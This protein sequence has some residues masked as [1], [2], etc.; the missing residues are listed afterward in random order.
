MEDKPEIEKEK[1][2]ET[3]NIQDFSN[4]AIPMIYDSIF[5]SPHHQ[6]KGP[7]TSVE[8]LF[9]E[10]NKLE[11]EKNITI[12][13]SILSFY[14]YL[15]CLAND[16][17][18]QS[19]IPEEYRGAIKDI[20]NF[21]YGGK[22]L[23]IGGPTGL[24]ATFGDIFS[25]KP[26]KT[27][28]IN[29]YQEKFGPKNDLTISDSIKDNIKKTD[30]KTTLETKS[31]GIEDIEN[32]LTEKFDV[33]TAYGCLGREN[34]AKFSGSKFGPD[35]STKEKRQEILR[36]VASVIKINGLFIITIIR[37][38]IPDVENFW[39]LSDEEVKKINENISEGWR[40]K[41]EYDYSP[42]H[43]MIRPGF[44]K[45]EIEEAG[46]KIITPFGLQDKIFVLQFKGSNP[47]N[48]HVYPPEKE[49][50]L[51]ADNN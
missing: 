50:P 18:T 9:E 45:D 14:E 20:R 44:E 29:P 43:F 4:L 36:Q 8:E 1:Y 41:K 32:E 48:E 15:S 46:F 49:Q 38:F 10:K 33:V 30:L 47:D 6:R 12:R 31:F 3:S 17:E 42:S 24:G 51:S 40:I 35:L 34:F 23:E 26:E 37:D 13:G 27:V 5:Y 7:L 2:I 28:I 21:T 16:E 22:L 11:K 25:L 19:F 39:A